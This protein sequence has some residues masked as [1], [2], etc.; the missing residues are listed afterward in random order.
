MD[1]ALTIGCSAFAAILS[2]WWTARTMRYQQ[3]ALTQAVELMANVVL[4]MN[5]HS[6]TLLE[7]QRQMMNTPRGRAIKT[8]TTETPQPWLAPVKTKNNGH[9]EAPPPNVPAGRIGN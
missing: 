1:I 7:F 6:E 4:S 5:Q 8:V 9:A 3:S 2:A